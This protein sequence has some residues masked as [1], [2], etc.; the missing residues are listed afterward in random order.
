MKRSIAVAV[1]VLLLA[2]LVLYGFV[3]RGIS[4]F[5]PGVMLACIDVDPAF[6]A[7]HCKSMLRYRPLAPDQVAE[8]NATA[9]IRLPLHL[10]DKELGLELARSFMRQGVDINAR[11]LLHK[12]FTALHAAAISAELDV[13]RALLDLGARIDLTDSEGRTPLQVAQ[14]AAHR[15]PDEPQRKEM[16]TLLERAASAAGK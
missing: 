16:V 9:G 1:G 5:P 15:F 12:R 2:A 14:T 7:W 10:A 3:V 4:K 11:E 13:S 8:L 6:I